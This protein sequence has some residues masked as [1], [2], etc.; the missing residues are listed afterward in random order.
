MSKSFW[1][2]LFVFGMVVCSALPSPDGKSETEKN[3]ETVKSSSREA[4]F[5]ER[6][7]K[8]EIDK[9]EISQFMS[10]KNVIKTL[11]KLI[12]GSDEESAATS[13]KILHLLVN[14]LDMLKTTLGQRSRS[15]QARSV[16]DTL[17]EAALAGASMLKGYVKSILT[18][19]ARCAQKYICEASKDAVK[20]GDKIGYIVAQFG[21][22]AVSY[23]LENQKLIPFQMNYNAS[24]KGRSG[25]DCLSIF[26]SCNETE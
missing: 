19:D 25:E 2:F 17:D 11:V 12:F 7:F 21:G 10:S 23:M 16:R 15:S 26:Q 18:R 13:R 5:D 20:E 3:T 4:R 22:Y 14:V 1:F 6:K 9:N 8:Q 24:R